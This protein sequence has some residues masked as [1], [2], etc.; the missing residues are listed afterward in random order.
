MKDR[1]RM[2]TPLKNKRF[3]AGIVAQIVGLIKAGET[4]PRTLLV[5]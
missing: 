4:T 1:Q 3:S 5:V 2:F